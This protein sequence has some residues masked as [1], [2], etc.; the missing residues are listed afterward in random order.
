MEQVANYRGIILGGSVVKVL[1]R[2]L[3]R[4]F[5]SVVGVVRCMLSV[6]EG[7]EEFISGLPEY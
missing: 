5:G 4:R 2:V 1:V 7:E 3:M 6:E